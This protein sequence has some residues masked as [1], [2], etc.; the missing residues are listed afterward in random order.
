LESVFEDN[1]R[2]RKWVL[3][4]MQTNPVSFSWNKFLSLAEQ[5]KHW[6]WRELVS[7]TGWVSVLVRSLHNIS[8]RDSSSLRAVG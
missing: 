7:G 2:A 8:L 4:V 3:A 5:G 1:S 6:L